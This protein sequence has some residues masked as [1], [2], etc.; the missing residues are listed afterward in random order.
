MATE[1][2]KDQLKNWMKDQL[3]MSLTEGARKN[4]HSIVVG[5]MTNT[6]EWDQYFEF[7]EEEK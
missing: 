4:A 1:W 3:D 5:I 7:E 2:K 6:D